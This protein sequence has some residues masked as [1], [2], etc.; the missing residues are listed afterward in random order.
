VRYRF[1]A[2]LRARR[3]AWLGVAAVI[4]LSAGLVLALVAGARRSDS[5]VERFI[6]YADP[7]EHLVISGIAGVFDFAE[8]DPAEVAALPGVA[9]SVQVPVL[10]NAGRTDAGR[11][12]DSGS[13]NLLADPE[14]RVGSTFSRFKFLSGRPADPDDPHEVVAEFRAAEALDLHVGSTL[15]AN[16]L[17]GEDLEAVFAGETT[18]E[19]LSLAEPREP[20]RVV[21]IAVAAGSLS[22]PEGADTTSVWLT[23]AAA[24]EFGEAGFV[25][26]VLIDLEEGPAGSREFLDRVESLGGGQPVLTQNTAEDAEVSDEGV[27]PIVRALI[28]AA[29]LIGLV[30]V[31][32]AG[33]VLSRQAG[34]EADDDPTLRALGWTREQLLRLRVAKALAIGIVA[35]LVSVIVA[36]MVSPAFPLG[37]ARIVEPDPGLAVD[38]TVLVVGFVAVLATVAALAG[39]TGWWQLRRTT[40]ARVARPSRVVG[41]LT[42]SGAPPP[43]LAGTG[44]ALQ[45]PTP[46]A[47]AP[48][49]AAATTMVLG[50]STVIA[51]LCFMASLAHLTDTPRLYGWTWDV[52]LGQ[53]FA[54]AF[55]DEELDWLRADEDVAALAVGTNA[56]LDVGDGPVQAY[57]VDD[58]IGQL[59]PSLIRG[60]A[61]EDIG[62]VV[63]TPG[64]GDIGERLTARFGGEELEL[65]VVGHAAI[66]AADAIITF[67]SLQRLAPESARQVVLVDLRPGT[68]VEAFVERVKS[69]P[70][71]RTEQDIQVPVL[72]DDLVNF[73]R[74]DAAP[75]LVAGSMALVAVATLLHALVSTVRRRLRDVAVLRVLGFTGRQVLATVSWQATTLVLVAAVP[76]LLIGVVVGR[77]AWQYFADELRVVNEPVVPV[78]LILGATLGSLL[79]A[80]LVAFSAGRWASRRSAAVILRSE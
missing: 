6:E 12:F 27:T 51:V 74:V 67:E 37:L 48:V 72:P 31:L 42:A 29:V 59:E 23:P 26:T 8:I 38:G 41:A 55:T 40:S 5:A 53:D 58:D 10:T 22:P 36:V 65:E 73:G 63:V 16:L 69:P 24:E 32:V 15:N 39:L 9:D 50:V 34:N 71:A 44:L 14:G 28:L 18:F 78:L 64:T 45:S 76:A 19:E 35:G 70:V 4:G 17:E 7:P 57:A 2:E 49:W 77:W 54:T 13:L 43:V 56:I 46:G 75:A 60:Q 66:P 25:Q 52:E 79:L 61:A 47:P 80:N 11:L 68:D 62:E 20:L 21:G 3:W 30:T 1:V 33:Q